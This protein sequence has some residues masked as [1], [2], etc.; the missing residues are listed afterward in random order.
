MLEG[1]FR[2]FSYSVVGRLVADIAAALG[3]VEHA[4]TYAAL[5]EASPTPRGVAST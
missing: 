1:D 3:I 4:R 2:E 5:F